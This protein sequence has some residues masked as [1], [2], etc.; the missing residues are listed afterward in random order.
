MIWAIV[1][2]FLGLF[3]L[4]LLVSFWKIIALTTIG[5]LVGGPV[6]GVIGFILGLVVSFVG[7]TPKQQQFQSQNTHQTNNGS[8]ADS[9]VNIT[10]LTPIIRLVSQYAR[11]NGAGWTPEKVTFVKSIFEEY[12]DSEADLKYLRE[13]LKENNINSEEQIGIILAQNID[14]AMRFRIFELCAQA[15]NFNTI[16]D[17]SM[18]QALTHLGRHLGISEVD[19]Q[20]IIHLF[21]TRD[22][23]NNNQEQYTNNDSRQQSASSR[24]KEA[25]ELLGVAVS[26]TKEEVIKAYRLKMMH[27]HPDKNPN[28]TPEVREVLTQKS[29]EL[30]EAKEKIVRHLERR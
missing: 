4:G 1:I 18:E 29:I 23:Q 11:F 15:I 28:V 10:W 7:N 21:K 27:F 12:C 14:Y 6:G 26:A 24:L 3:F 5:V 2:I 17:R 13:L 30:Q 16:S 20:N 8:H 25:Y 9:A 19:Y 22:G